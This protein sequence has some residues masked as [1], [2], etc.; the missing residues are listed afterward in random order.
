MDNDELTLEEKLAR[1]DQK[2]PLVGYTNARR[3]ITAVRRMKA[4]EEMGIPIQH[5]TGFAISTKTGRHANEMAK[6]EWDDFYKGLC[7]ELKKQYPE[8][9]QHLFPEGKD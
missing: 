5:R 2:F 3:I 1:L 6:Q 7:G 9:Y 8:E 4:E